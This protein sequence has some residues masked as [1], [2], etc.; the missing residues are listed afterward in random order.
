MVL[1]TNTPPKCQ[2]RNCQNKVEFKGAIYCSEHSCKFPFCRKEG[3]V[4]KL[5]SCDEHFPKIQKEYFKFTCK[6]IKLL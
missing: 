5:S 3:F 6:K 2:T 1:I 4:N